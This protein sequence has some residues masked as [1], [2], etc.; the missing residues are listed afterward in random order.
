MPKDKYT[1][2]RLEEVPKLQSGDVLI[3]HVWTYFD[4]GNR[5]RHV[6]EVLI[7][8]G[9]LAHVFD[10]QGSRSA[11]HA[12][13]VGEINDEARIFEADSAGILVKSLAE[14]ATLRDSNAYTVF[15]HGGNEPISQ[16]L[17][18]LCD[19]M[20]T[21]LAV[22]QGQN[23]PAI[24]MSRYQ[25]LPPDIKIREAANKAHLSTQ[26]QKTRYGVGNMFT[27]AL[28][29]LIPDSVYSQ[30]HKRILEFIEGDRKEIAYICSGL[31]AVLLQ[32]WSVAYL[33]KRVFNDPAQIHPKGLEH[34]FLKG[35]FLGLTRVGRWGHGND[36]A[37]EEAWYSR[38]RD[39]PALAGLPLPLG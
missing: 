35:S 14:T 29:N 7:R 39:L 4:G 18:V 2:S 13:M 36:G 12:C 5:D 16:G 22:I 34:H 15:R 9:G 1:W 24:T 30:H 11:E 33:G 25:A 23:P 6:V 37:G 10:S 26:Q 19:A 21:R 38:F 20:A 8:A 3:K 31:V 17:K 27:M 32:A 28:P